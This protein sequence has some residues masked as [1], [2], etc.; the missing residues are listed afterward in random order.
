MGDASDPSSYL[1][2]LNT[3]PIDI[4]IDA[5]TA[6]S[7]APSILS[8]VASVSGQ[9]LQTLAA[10]EAHGSKIGFVYISGTWVH[11]APS[12]QVSDLHPIGSKELSKSHPPEVSEWRVGHEQSILATRDTLEV[13][14]VRPA[15]VYGAKSWL[16]EDIWGP[17]VDA[18]M[19]GGHGGTEAATVK[20]PIR[21][22][23]Y[24]GVV[25]VDDVASGVCAI[26]DRI[27]G[28]LGSWPVFDLATETVGMRAMIEAVREV[29]GCSAKVEM[30]DPGDHIFHKALSLRSK[31][32]AG[33]RARIVLGWQ[34]KRIEMLERLAVY[35]K[36]F[37]AARG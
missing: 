27:F 34:P 32:G 11:G 14:I 1:S 10:S 13:A 15:E 23:A 17:I 16:Y 9:R 37:E 20:V 30:V 26:S 31:A 2:V 33:E 24:A 36:A 7:H 22:G 19:S 12:T 6:Y 8:T 28:G 25:H 18:A 4:V 5:S 21:E 29:V 3:T 35:V